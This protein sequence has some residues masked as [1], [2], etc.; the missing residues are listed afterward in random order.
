LKGEYWND[1]NK[2]AR[3]KS[4]GVGCG[5]SNIVELWLEVRLQ[6]A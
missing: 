3:G 6:E 1:W 2:E 4:Q 5:G